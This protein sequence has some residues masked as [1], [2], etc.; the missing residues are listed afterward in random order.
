MAI[1]VLRKGRE[2]QEAHSADIPDPQVWR[3]PP[4]WRKQNSQANAVCTSST[5]PYEKMCNQGLSIPVGQ[6]APVLCANPWLYLVVAEQ[7][8][9]WEIK[10]LL[11]FSNL[12]VSFFKYIKLNSCPQSTVVNSCSQVV[13]N[14]L[15]VVL[16]IKKVSVP[17]KTMW[18]HRKGR[19]CSRFPQLQWSS[20]WS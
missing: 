15:I 8:F 3:N 9:N 6:P 16:K 13:L 1:Y 18:C 4:G 11:P 17:P 7:C 20:S 19:E 2:F 14:N 5:C 12:S 10:T